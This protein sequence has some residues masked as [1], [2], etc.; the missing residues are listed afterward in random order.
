MTFKREVLRIFLKYR[1][2]LLTPKK[3]WMWQLKI[4]GRIQ[5]F[6]GILKEVSRMNN[7][8]IIYFSTTGNTEKVALAIKRGLERGGFQ[9]TVKT[10][11]EVDGE[12]FYNKDFVCIGSPTLHSLPPP[13]VFDFLKKLEK[14]FRSDGFV[15]LPTT[16]LINKNAL[17]FCTYSGPHCGVNEALPAGKYIR[18]FFEH[19]GFD[20]KGEWYEAGEFHGWEHGSTGG[21]LGDLRGRPDE[22]DLALIEL[23]TL[24]LTKSL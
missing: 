18:Q 10:V 21:K 3:L 1:L 24:Q 13:P 2:R 22:D 14:K 6:L 20:V 15:Q 9:V 11:D 23:K 17:I 5:V 12:E 4:L 7:A 16:E 8:L 19:L